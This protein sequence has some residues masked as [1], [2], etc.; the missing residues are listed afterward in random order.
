LKNQRVFAPPAA[1]KEYTVLRLVPGALAAAVLLVSVGAAPAL[2]VAPPAVA[3]VPLTID[4]SLA[5]A[6]INST[7][8]AEIA[9]A[10]ERITALT[11]MR[12]ART[13]S[14]V[15]LPLETIVADLNDD[16]AAQQFLTN[17]STDKAVRDASLQCNSDQ[18]AFL[19]EVTAR[20]AL[21]EALKAAQA[22]HTALGDAQTKLT[23]LW[24]VASTRAGAGLPDDKRAEFIKLSAQLSDLQNQFGSNLGND[25]STISITAAQTAGLPADF[26]ATF[27]KTATGYSVPVNESTLVPFMQNANDE[28]ARQSFYTAYSNRGA[29][30][31]VALL[32]QA[33]GIRDRLAHLFGYPSWAAYV[34]A[35]KMAQTPQRVDT[36][37]ANI[38]SAI[39]PKARAERAELA[40]LKGNGT[41]YSWDTQ[42]YQTKLRKQKYSV[43]QNAIKQYFPVQHTVTAVLGIY[44]KLLDVTFAPIAQSNVYN[45][46]VLAYEVHDGT[47]GVLLGTFDLDLYPR[48][49]KYD[50][51]ANFPLIARRVLP[52][53]TVRAPFSVI[54]GNWSRPAPGHPAVLSHGEVE[55]FFHEFGHNMAAMLAD[56]PYAT[57]TSGFRSDFIEAPSQMLE[58]WVWDPGILKTISSNVT[59]GAPLPDD[60]IAKMIAARYLDY[61]L[62]TTQQILYASVDMKYHSSGATVDTTASWKES[63]AALT[64]G[65]FVDGTHPQAGFGHLMGGYDA[66]YYGYLWSKVYAQDMF[67]AF[68]AAGLEDPVVGA[69]Y[70]DDILAP[71]RTYEP[72]AE[73]A[74]FL[75][76]PMSPTAFYAELGIAPQTTMR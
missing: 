54:V 74:R 1:F 37:L 44:A 47:N 68:K 43:D 56:E 8:K 18:S 11:R 15:V 40:A 72:D 28:S 67:S 48:P 31:N 71:A 60:L 25:A 39:L 61:A 7:C 63:V 4:W 52:D 20:P 22:S 3:A 5:P 45:P 16:T 59:T 14:T 69:R 19:S 17:V 42:Y 32:E 29:P 46:E 51:F 38:D 64:P 76:R 62:S 23:D 27:T 58:N 2:P 34:L 33:I 66:G 41:F 10:D 50:H 13:F 6:Q 70:R 9:R 75:A 21:F 24:L 65:T 30:K 26:V 36:F 35:D 73:V 49:G 53:G 12:S 57:L 55:T